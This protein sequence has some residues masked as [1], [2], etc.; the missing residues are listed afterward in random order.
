MSAQAYCFLNVLL[1][2]FKGSNSDAALFI[3]N[4]N[5]ALSITFTGKKWAASSPESLFVV[6][7]ILSDT[8]PSFASLAESQLSVQ[9]P[10]VFHL[11]SMPAALASSLTPPLP[12][13]HYTS[14]SLAY[15]TA[16]LVR[17]LSHLE[18][19]TLLQAIQALL[20]VIDSW[21]WI[22]SSTVQAISAGCVCVRVRKR[23]RFLR[24]LNNNN[25]I[26]VLLYSVSVCYLRCWNKIPTINITKKEHL[27][28][29]ENKFSFLKNAKLKR[30]K[31]YLNKNIKKWQK[32][33]IWK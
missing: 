7:G 17:H 11:L 9:I 31:M 25:K 8:K 21:L 30:K 29:T 12:T 13:S 32:H 15:P 20:D 4:L 19:Y 26:N 3:C 2:V 1:C 33:F 28:L 24:L 10:T 14:W 6:V 27:Q 5:A 18:Q 23:V 22:L 16:W